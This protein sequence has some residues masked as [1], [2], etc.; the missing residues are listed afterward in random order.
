[1][2]CDATAVFSEIIRDRRTAHASSTIGHPSTTGIGDA[3]KTTI[4][5]ALN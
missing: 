2:G 4:E 3:I 5:I 1:M